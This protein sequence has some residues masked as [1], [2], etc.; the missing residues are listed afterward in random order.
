MAGFT[1]APRGAYEDLARMRFATRMF[2]EDLWT[3]ADCYFQG[4]SYTSTARVLEEYLHHEA[5][6]VERPGAGAAGP[7]AAGRR[8][9]RRSNRGA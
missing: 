9:V 4:Q 1:S 3:A 2:P 6:R 7:V 5:R 8:Q